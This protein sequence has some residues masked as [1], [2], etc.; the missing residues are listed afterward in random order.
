M[1]SDWDFFSRI[2]IGMICSRLSTAASAWELLEKR[3][4]ETLSLVRVL[5]PRNAKTGMM[6]S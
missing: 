6:T 5:R 1:L 4:P 3:S 2:E